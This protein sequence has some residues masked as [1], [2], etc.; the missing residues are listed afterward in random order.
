M[1]KLSE[2]IDLLNELKNYYGDMPVYWGVDEFPCWEVKKNAV[3][4]DV[5]IKVDYVYERDNPDPFALPYL[6]L[7]DYRDVEQLL[8]F[9]N[10]LYTPTA[11]ERLK[12]IFRIG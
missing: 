1:V 7:A 11:V 12:K 5:P 10:K 3:L 4:K 6:Y 8:D 2:L 9:Q